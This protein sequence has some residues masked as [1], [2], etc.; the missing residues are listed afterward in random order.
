[1]K[2]TQLPLSDCLSLRILIWAPPALA[3]ISLIMHPSILIKIETTEY[4]CPNQLGDKVVRNQE[5]DDIRRE[6]LALTLIFMV[7][8]EH[9]NYCVY[10]SCQFS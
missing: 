3:A 1:M 9:D 4:T 10:D 8:S 7:S 6:V 2:K 5:L